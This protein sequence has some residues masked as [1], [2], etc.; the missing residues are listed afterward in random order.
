MSRLTLATASPDT[1][2]AIPLDVLFDFT[3]V[4]IIGDKA[5]DTDLRMDFA[6]TDLDQTETIWIRRGVLNA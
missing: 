3:G 6:F 5:V 2:A 4:H 1:L